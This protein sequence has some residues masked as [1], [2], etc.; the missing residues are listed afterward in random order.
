MSLQYLSKVSYL[1]NET[2]TNIPADV[3]QDLRRM[4]NPDEHSRPSALDFTSNKI[5]HISSLS[6]LFRVEF[7][8]L[9]LLVLFLFY[10][11]NYHIT[12]VKYNEVKQ[13]LHNI[14]LQACLITHR[15]LSGS[16]QNDHYLEEICH[17]SDLHWSRS[18]WISC[19][20]NYRHSM[21]WTRHHYNNSLIHLSRVLLFLI[22]NCGFLQL[23]MGACNI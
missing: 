6:G 8:F 15:E 21:C 22:G 14:F 20:M 13:S 1:P 2:F 10:I 12:Y 18:F 4:L 23:S 11:W 7:L 16:T 17:V 19:K 9:C 3:V 5:V